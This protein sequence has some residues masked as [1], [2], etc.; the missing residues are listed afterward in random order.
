MEGIKLARY[1]LKQERP[2]LVM[3]KRRA[4]PGNF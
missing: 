4:S 2:D 3:V 1:R